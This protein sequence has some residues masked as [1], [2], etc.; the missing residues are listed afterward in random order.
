MF[1]KLRLASIIGMIL[2]GSLVALAQEP[3]Q[4]PATPREEIRR[5]HMKLRERHREMRQ[6]HREM[7]SHGGVGMGFRQL[8]LTDAQRDQMRTIRQK[9]LEALKSQREE[10]FKMREKR[11]AGTFSPADEARVKALRE[12]IRTAMSGIRAETEA[13][14][15][16]EQKARL[17]QLKTEHKARFAERSANRQA[18]R[19]LRMKQRQERLKLRQQRLK[20]NPL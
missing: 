8:N 7:R 1:S 15:T 6:R 3:T 20:T 5:E 13:V 18:H 9:R 14:L 10:L 4:T 16:T 17:E 19:E 11:I 12:E 2:A